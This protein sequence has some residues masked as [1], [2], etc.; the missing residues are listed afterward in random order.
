[1]KPRA[2]SRRQVRLVS[3]GRY[4]DFERGLLL[5]DLTKAGTSRPFD[6]GAS[7]PGTKVASFRAWRID[8]FLSV[9][10]RIGRSPAITMEGT[11]ACAASIL[12]NR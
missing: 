1:M 7:V 5:V 4:A 12:F 11:G 9:E 10:T 3:A 6:P 8:L 2:S